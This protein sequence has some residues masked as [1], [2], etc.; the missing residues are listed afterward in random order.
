M[1][2]PSQQD[3]K[4]IEPGDNPL[5][6]DAINEK[7]RNRRLVFP[8]MVQEHVLNIL[9]LLSG[10]RTILFVVALTASAHTLSGVAV[11]RCKTCTTPGGRR[12]SAGPADHG[13]AISR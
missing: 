7:H 10:H 13:F 5:K 4:V 3:G 11:W 8:H 2:I 9:R 1:A 12:A 6:F